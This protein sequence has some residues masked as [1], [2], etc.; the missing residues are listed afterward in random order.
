VTLADDGDTE[1]LTVVVAGSTVTSALAILVGSAALVA[2]MVTLVALFTLGAVNLPPSVM[3]P[4]L[5]DHCTPVLLVPLTVAVNCC[6]PPAVMVAAV[7]DTVTLTLGAAAE[8][9]TVALALLVVSATLV[10]RTVT[11]VAVVTF[12]AANVPVLEIVPALA[13][14][15]TPVLL[16]PWT[17]AENCCV[18]PDATLADVGVMEMLTV[19][20]LPALMVM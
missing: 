18:P 1:T 16:A 5:V 6:A 17:L 14:H 12:G 4:E 20:P 15:V 9:D 13:D 11:V 19:D 10:A 3:D 8:I 2:R 7:G